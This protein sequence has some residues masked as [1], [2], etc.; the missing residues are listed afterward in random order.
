MTQSDTRHNAVNLIFGDCP[1]TKGIS[2]AFFSGVYGIW[3]QKGYAQSIDDDICFYIGES[4]CISERL[5]LPKHPSQKNKHP[6]HEYLIDKFGVDRLYYTFR[7]FQRE[8][9]RKWFEQLA[10]GIIRPPLNYTSPP[11]PDWDIYGVV[12]FLDDCGGKLCISTLRGVYLDQFKGPVTRYSA[13][14]GGTVVYQPSRDVSIGDDWGNI[15]S[16][17]SGY[18]S[19][20]H[21]S[22]FRQKNN[23][24]QF[25]YAPKLTTA[26][27]DFEL[28]LARS[29]MRNKR[30][31]PQ[32]LCFVQGYAP[33]LYS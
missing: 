29:L 15:W 33:I 5:A 21:S 6:Q 31:Y 18:G 3:I 2:V 13:I 32:E 24:N 12:P 9:D 20:S 11:Y 28:A 4:G 27:V 7:K 25:Y 10:I 17:N 30:H 14:P 8:Q 16:N 22:I 26:P 1:L 23:Q 19:P